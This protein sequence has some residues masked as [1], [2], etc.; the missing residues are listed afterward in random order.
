M[1]A[2]T[3]GQTNAAF[4]RAT[5]FV[6]SMV[7]AL[8]GLGRAEGRDLRALSPAEREDLGLSLTDMNRLGV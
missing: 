8:I 1:S 3:F 2:S 7:I 6:A 4:P 5:G